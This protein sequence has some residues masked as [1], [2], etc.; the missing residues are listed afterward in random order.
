MIKTLALLSLATLA[1]TAPVEDLVD[2]LPDM[3]DGKSFPFK[4][5]SGYLNVAGTTR[6]L[7]YFFVESQADSSTSPLVVWF[8]GGPGCSSMLGLLTEHG[9]YVMENEGTTF[10]SNEYS[11]NKFAN[12]LYIESPAGVGYSYYIEEDDYNYTDYGVAQDNM[13][14]LIYFLEM[15]FPEY[16]N[17]DLYLSGESYAGIYVPTLAYA[18]NDY[19]N[20]AKK[21]AEE[22]NAPTFIVNLKGFM[23]GN[24]VTN[25]KYD[26]MPAYVEMA[27]WHGLYDLDMYNEIYAAGCPK[28]FEYLA[29]D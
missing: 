25:W 8:N 7:H 20:A 13:K 29:V 24:G 10:H 2:S 15:K 3:N 23:V 4:T 16:K 26:T 18:I 21:Y 27:Y 28:E 6:N 17:N 12:M 11:W 22:T 19:N 9:P 1:C 14:A 5:Y